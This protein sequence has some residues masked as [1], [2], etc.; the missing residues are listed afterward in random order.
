MSCSRVAW[1][2]EVGAFSQAVNRFPTPQVA[3][4][5]T[6]VCCLDD[7]DVCIGCGRTMAEICEWSL[8]TDERRL[9]IN[10]RARARFDALRAERGG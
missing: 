5:C 2:P 4:P 7:Q 1:I 6:R 8:C 10:V 3:S 9:E